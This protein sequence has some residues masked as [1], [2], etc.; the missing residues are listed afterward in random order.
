MCLSLAMDDVEH[1][2]MHCPYFKTIRGNMLS[3]I[4][5]IEGYYQTTIMPPTDNNLHILLG[6]TNN[7]Q[8][9]EAM[10]EFYKVVATNVHQMYTTT[11]RNREG[12]G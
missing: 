2:I 1:L 8:S 11:V 5:R 10:F 12:V 7:E 3:E 6:K 9:Y 4:S